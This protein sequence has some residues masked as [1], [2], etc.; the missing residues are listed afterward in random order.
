MV[1]MKIFFISTLFLF[2]CFFIINAWD[3]TSETGETSET[4]ETSETG[5][6]SHNELSINLN[7]IVEY[8]N[9][10][11]EEEYKNK[12]INKEEYTNKNSS[13]NNAEQIKIQLR[14]AYKVGWDLWLES[15]NEE[16]VNKYVLNRL[17]SIGIGQ[18]NYRFIDNITNYGYTIPNDA[19]L[20]IV[21]HSNSEL[22]I[23]KKIDTLERN[24][25]E[26]NEVKWRFIYRA[27]I[28]LEYDNLSSYSINKIKEIQ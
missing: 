4:S 27:S 11:H 26:L 8:P 10:I 7:S 3:V 19:I 16:N 6:K 5:E 22:D 1:N 21:N 18:S 15:L 20:Y 25:Y 12:N 17:L 2:F 23:I 24:G 9:V 13:N 28:A 14:S